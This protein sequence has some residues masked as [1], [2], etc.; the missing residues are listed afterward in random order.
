M[1]QYDNWKAAQEAAAE[2][3][4]NSFKIAYVIDGEVVETLRTNERLWAVIMS[5][6]TIVDFTDI[7][8]PDEE[9]EDGTRQVSI[10]TGWKYDGTTFTRPTE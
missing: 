9:T 6:P 4:E 5:N 3:E 7:A 10:T 1:T 8:F 2:P